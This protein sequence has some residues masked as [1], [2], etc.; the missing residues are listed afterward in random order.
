MPVDAGASRHG[1]VYQREQYDKGGLGRAYW[2]YRD[3]RIIES[4]GA[5]GGRIADVGCGEGVLLEKLL[6]RYPASEVEGLDMDPLNV[7]ICETLGL[8]VRLAGAYE[9]PYPDHSVDVCLFIE[10][11]EH[12]DDPAR[13]I[14]ELRRVLKPGGRLITLFPNDYTFKLARLLTLRFKEAFYDAGHLRQWTPRAMREALTAGGFSVLSEKSLPINFFPLALH[15]LT[16]AAAPP[17]A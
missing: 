11:I 16:V 7:E 1:V 6:M 10:V 5:G 12:L 4:I 15:H 8:P 3:G 13:A 9:L 2:D 14:T 17:G